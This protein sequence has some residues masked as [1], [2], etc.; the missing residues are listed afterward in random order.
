[1]ER[2]SN[3]FP[4]LQVTVMTLYSGWIPLFMAAVLGVDRRE[5]GREV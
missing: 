1:V 3:V 2:V 4:Q 5:K